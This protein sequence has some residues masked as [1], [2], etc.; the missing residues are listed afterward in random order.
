[1]KVVLDT[2]IL[3]S[4]LLKPQSIPARILDWVVAGKLT[5]VVDERIVAEY[6]EVLKRK[7]FG[8]D[9]TLVLD[10]I[11]YLRQV[12]EWVSAIPLPLK[13]P[14]PDDLPFLEVAASGEV[15]ALITGNA[16][17]FSSATHD[18]KIYTPTQFLKF[19][20]KSN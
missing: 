12:A 2:N 15:E 4:A 16:K 18:V 7:K 11:N 17:D 6:H 13:I 1:V 14:D 10:F 8:F 5:L 3:V 19:F 9:G 20:S